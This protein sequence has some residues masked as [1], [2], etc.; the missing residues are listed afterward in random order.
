[1]LFIT[2][3]MFSFKL[4]SLAQWFVA[5]ASW[6]VPVKSPSNMRAHL[7]Q[8]T[9]QSVWFHS[10]RIKGHSTQTPISIDIAPSSKKRRESEGREEG[11]NVRER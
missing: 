1:M 11:S 4:V 9:R 7:M 3:N 8:A 5:L 10:A 6:Q 2:L